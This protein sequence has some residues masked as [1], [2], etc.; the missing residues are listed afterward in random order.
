M[1]NMAGIP[2]GND[3]VQLFTPAGE[4][5]TTITAPM[6]QPGSFLPGV[7]IWGGRYFRLESGRYVE[8]RAYTSIEAPR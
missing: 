5:V 2:P 7:V 4:Y 8:T 1:A 6:D 3:E